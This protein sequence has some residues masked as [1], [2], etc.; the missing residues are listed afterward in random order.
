MAAT[1]SQYQFP[2]KVVIAE[3]CVSVPKSAKRARLGAVEKRVLSEV[4]RRT[5]EA[6]KSLKPKK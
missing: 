3:M 6:A 5:V 2:N 4:T 1:K